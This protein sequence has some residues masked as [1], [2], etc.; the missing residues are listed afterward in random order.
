MNRIDFILEALGE[1]R[2]RTFGKR[3]SCCGA[4]ASA[5]DGEIE[6][7]NKLQNALLLTTTGE[8]GRREQHHSASETG[9]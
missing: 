1:R 7:G 4:W 9:H 3:R 8:Q 6:G 2:Q 5:V